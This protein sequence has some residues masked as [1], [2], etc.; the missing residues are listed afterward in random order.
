M[1]HLPGVGPR[2]VHTLWKELDVESVEELAGLDPGQISSLK[3]FG[4]KSAEKILR[5]AR[6]YNATRNDGCSSTK[7]TA[8]GEEIL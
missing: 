7:A 4:K 6:T 3:G 5:A 1:T 2:T 8:L